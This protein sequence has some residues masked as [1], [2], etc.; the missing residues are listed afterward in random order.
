VLENGHVL[1]RGQA[2]SHPADEGLFRGSICLA[3]T[4]AECAST[5]LCV[6]LLVVVIVVGLLASGY[7]NAA[8]II[9]LGALLGAGTAIHRHRRPKS[10]PVDLQGWRMD[11]SGNWRWWDG[12][13]WAD[14]PPGETPRKVG[15]E[16]EW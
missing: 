14:A 7:P 9:V 10:P 6:P 5:D 12:S 11:D 13:Q 1:D 16:I 2:E 3:E 15:P 8:F 4:Q